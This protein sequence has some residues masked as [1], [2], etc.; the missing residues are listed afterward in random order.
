MLTPGVQ[1]KISRDDDGALIGK[2]YAWVRASLEIRNP[3]LERS[4]VRAPSSGRPFI[5]SG[6]P[7]GSAISRWRIGEQKYIKN[8]D[9]IV[10]ARDSLMADTFVLTVVEASATRMPSP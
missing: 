10:S 5:I 3:Y 8:Q 9:L 1:V 7:T 2:S 4:N 6:V